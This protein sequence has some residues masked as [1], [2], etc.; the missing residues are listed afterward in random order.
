MNAFWTKCDNI[1]ASLGHLHDFE[2][3][4]HSDVHGVI[5]LRAYSLQYTMIHVRATLTARATIITEFIICDIPSMIVLRHTMYAIGSV[6][7]QNEI[8]FSPENFESLLKDAFVI[9]LFTESALQIRFSRRC[10]ALDGH[11]EMGVPWRHSLLFYRR[12][13]G[14]RTKLRLE[15]DILIGEQETDF[16]VLNYCESYVLYPTSNTSAFQPI[17]FKKT[18]DFI[19]FV[20]EELSRQSW[21]RTKSGIETVNWDALLRI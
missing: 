18:T 17:V 20:E 7:S 12:C 16:L 14:L 11:S 19:R 10:L 13:T 15:V 4:T 1:V 2:F 3:K 8:R 5:E 21:M 9:L 6:T